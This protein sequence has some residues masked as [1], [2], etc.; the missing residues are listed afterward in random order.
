MPPDSQKRV[1][2][3][4]S[5][6]RAGLG[7]HKLKVNMCKI[8]SSDAPA[9]ISHAPEDAKEIAKKLIASGV[10]N[11]ECWA[12]LQNTWPHICILLNKNSNYCYIPHS[13]K[14]TDTCE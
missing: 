14:H 4:L 5:D 9:E 7:F 11:I 3:M 1:V 2:L 10:C 13:S 6:V 12:K 8:F